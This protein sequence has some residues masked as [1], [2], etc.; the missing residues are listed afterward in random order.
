MKRYEKIRQMSVAELADYL[1]KRDIDVADE[2]C[3]D[4]RFRDKFGCMCNECILPKSND[5]MEWLCMEV[6]DV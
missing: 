3:H 2:V 4:C 1:N 6:Q 5:V